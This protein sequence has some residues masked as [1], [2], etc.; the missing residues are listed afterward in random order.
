[1]A[2]QMDRVRDGKRVL[3]DEVEPLVGVGDLDD[4]LLVRVGKVAVNDLL[5]GCGRGR[6]C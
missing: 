2:V 6:L 1:V 4:N 5:D 3:D